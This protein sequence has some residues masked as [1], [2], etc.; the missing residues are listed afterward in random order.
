MV[1]LFYFCRESWLINIDA[2]LDLHAKLSTVVRYYDRMLE[3]RLSNTYNQH[4]I[5]GYNLPPPQRAGSNMYPTLANAPE[6]AGGAESFYTGNAPAQPYGR[7]QSTYYAPP[8]QQSSSYDKRASIASPGYPPVEQ[9]NDFTQYPPQAQALPQQGNWQAN[10]LSSTPTPANPGYSTPGQQND[11]YNQYPPQSHPQQPQRTPSFQTA[12]PAAT[13]YPAQ[14]SYVPEQQQQA[15]PPM[16]APSQPAMSPS[17]DPNAAFYFNNASQAPPPEQ[18]QPQYP[19]AQSPQQYQTMP[20]QQTSPQQYSNQPVKQ[21]T[22]PAPQYAAPP[23]Q[24]APYWQNAPAQQAWQAPGQTHNGYT[25]ESFPSAPHHAPQQ[26]V[27]EESL[28]EL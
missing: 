4:T 18:N 25:Q 5:G 21:Q 16:N 6:A 24:Q 1:S 10:D 12:N 14:A 2:L 3:E 7:P 13:P 11:A 23:Q 28:I 17:A 26:K 27:M 20:P 9:R 8:Q 15:P 22:A 19:P